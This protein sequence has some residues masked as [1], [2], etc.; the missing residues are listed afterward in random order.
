M[1]EISVQTGRPGVHQG[2]C[3]ITCF[4]PWPRCWSGRLFSMP[5]RGRSKGG[6]LRAR[7]RVSSRHHLP[8]ECRGLLGFYVCLELELLLACPLPT[9]CLDHRLRH[10]PRPLPPGHRAE[11][12]FREV[13]PASRCLDCTSGRKE[14][15]VRWCLVQGPGHSQMS[16]GS[17]SNTYDLQ[18]DASGKEDGQVHTE[19]LH[20]HALGAGDTEPANSTPVVNSVGEAISKYS[21]FIH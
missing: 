3:V 1:T 16:A 19:S 21:I 11:L 6:L 9:T 7:Q 10:F 17:V 12:W 2:P 14:G 18:K 8:A 15:P 13:E 4:L 5:K 20:C